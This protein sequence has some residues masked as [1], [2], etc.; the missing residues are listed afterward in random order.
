MH[1]AIIGITGG[2]GSGKSIVAKIFATLN[3]PVFD[4][5][6]AAKSLYETS[7]ELIQ[8]MR[9]YFGEQIF[10]DEKLDKRKLA[11]LV[12]SDPNGLR[13]LN[14]LVHPLVKERFNTWYD[15][16]ESRYVLREAAILIES[17]N[18]KDCSSIILVTADEPTKIDRVVKRNNITQLEVKRRMANQWDDDKK[19]P[20]ADFE[21]RN[22]NEDLILP[23]ILKIHRQLMA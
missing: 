16:Q 7:S 4:A 13:K 18:Y 14:S 5:D 20:F 8:S 23:Q 3:V 19:R 1:P 15:L 12:F 6:D 2:I 10:T 11:A 21:I 9:D 17:G 22:N